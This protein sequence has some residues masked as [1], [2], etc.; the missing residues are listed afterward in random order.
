MIF[1]ND[2]TR[3]LCPLFEAVIAEGMGASLAGG[4]LIGCVIADGAGF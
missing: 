1:L 2:I 4:G 3:Y